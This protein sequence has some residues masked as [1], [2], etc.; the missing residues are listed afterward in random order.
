MYWG[1]VCQHDESGSSCDLMG[2]PIPSAR[3][4][5]NKLWSLAASSE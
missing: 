1:M 2:E 5:S 3:T 4:R